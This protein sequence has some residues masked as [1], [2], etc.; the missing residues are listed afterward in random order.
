MHFHEFLICVATVNN[1]ERLERFLLSI[2]NHTQNIDYKISIT[3]DCSLPEFS[4]KNYNLAV[5]YSCYYHRNEQ[6]S[7]VPYS[8][9]RA[10]E[11]ADCKYLVIA[12][13]DI[14][15]VPGWLNAYKEFYEANKHLKLGV[16]AW[17]AVGNKSELKGLTEYLVSIDESHIVTPIVACVGYLFAV[18]RELFM[19]VGK[20]DERYFATWEEIDFG[21]KLCM[22]G[23]KSIGLSQPY[24]Y[25]QGG[26]SFSDPINQ[27]PAMQKQSLA[28]RQWIDKWSTILNI[29]RENKT[30][31]N[32]IFEIS[33][34]LTAKIPKYLKNDFNSITINS[35][36]YKKI[37][38][39][40]ARDDI[41]GW[42]DWQDIYRDAVKLSGYNSH[43]VEVGSWMGKSACFMGELIKASG[44]NI[45]FDCVDIWSD[46]CVDYAYSH[47]INDS[48]NTG[49][50]MLSK[51]LKNLEK[52][53]VQEYITP[54]KS[55]SWEAAS[56]YQDE[57]LDMVFLDAGHD[58]DSVM[59]DL[60]AWWP[61]I[62]N[63]GVFAGHDYNHS[64]DGV[65]LAVNEFFKNKKI[66]VKNNSWFIIK[67]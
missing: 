21:A 40:I 4:E 13:D 36:N 26:A 23:Y 25:H 15:V 19:M 59:K 17:P 34:N 11:L 62:K 66:I 6:R 32:L 9:N 22:L 58:Y 20:F 5:K 65:T 10:T 54:V 18:P 49:N 12:N 53:N 57:S 47:E 44:K 45:K 50:S 43:F 8:W 1:P 60:N 39:I 28:Q 64:Q 37:D 42:F 2:I 33:N 48:I 41:H 61:K 31:K 35:F 30:E 46:Y 52:Y 51:F 29:N 63:G 3:D 16:M 56:N 14:E 27:H 38:D 67:K 24:V 7:G 55:F